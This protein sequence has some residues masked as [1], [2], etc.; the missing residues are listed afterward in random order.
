MS[1]YDKQVENT[2]DL[3][4]NLKINEDTLSRNQKNFINENGFLVLP[5]PEFIKKNL[6]KLNKITSE[7]INF[8]GIKGGWEGKEENYKEGKPF[9]PNADRLGN[10]I[11]KNLIFAELITIPEILAAS[12]EV[13]KGD[14]KVG[15]LNLRNPHKNFGNQALHIDCFPRQKLD[16]PFSGVVCYI[17]L[18]ESTIENGATKII[19]KTHKK[20]GWP[21]DH[22]KTTAKHEKEFRAVVEAGSVIVLNLNTWHGGATNKNGNPRK[23]IFIQIKRR[24]EQQLLSY[25]KYLSDRTKK[26]LD[27]NQ[28]YLLAVREND[29]IQKENSYSVGKEYRKIFGKDRGTIK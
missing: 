28:K 11:E 27:E 4:N 24:E 21:D 14:L 7:L 20:L 15:G 18:D 9:E 1:V 3:L 12:H 19:P 8:E 6:K 25:K 16:E 26:K 5:P 17:Y 23:T 13:I 2:K 10:L 22:I 29:P